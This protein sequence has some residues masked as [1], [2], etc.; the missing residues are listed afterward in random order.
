MGIISTERPVSKK[1]KKKNE[2]NEKELDDD[3]V[4][5][6]EQDVTNDG[7]MISVYCEYGN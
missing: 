4:S 5:T 1:K 2:T 6:S 7:R 3:H